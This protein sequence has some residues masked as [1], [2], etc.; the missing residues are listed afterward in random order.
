[1]KQHTEEQCNATLH[2]AMA[3]IGATSAILPAIPGSNMVRI[4][5]DSAEQ[6]IAIAKIARSTPNYWLYKEWRKTQFLGTIATALPCVVP[7]PLAFLPAD[8]GC[9]DALL[10][11]HQPGDVYRSG[12]DLSPAQQQSFA[13]MAGRFAVSLADV[14]PAGAFSRAFLKP[15]KRTGGPGILPKHLYYQHFS[16][17]ALLREKDGG[18]WP[19]REF[20]EP[21]AFPILTRL[22]KTGETL[23]RKYY[24]EGGHPRDWMTTHV[25]LRPANA[26]FTNNDLTSIIDISGI[27]IAPMGYCLRAFNGLGPQAL[28]LFNNELAAGNYDPLPADMVQLHGVN[29]YAA[30]LIA[31]QAA[32][33]R[34]NNM[35]NFVKTDYPEENWCELDRWIT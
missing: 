33:Q 23:F 20:R 35:I 5:C 29:W 22:M 18:L 28:N 12:H 8:N 9:P 2:R 3:E 32:G 11:D 19:F 24:G 17:G 6:P 26:V 15:C 4:L 34:V 10:L 30:R 1:M 25:D 14:A 21:D 27:L 31:Q 16:R 13:R 7:K